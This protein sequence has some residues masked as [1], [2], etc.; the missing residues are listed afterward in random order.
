MA[1]IPPPPPLTSEEFKERV[2]AGAKTMKE[3]DPRYYAWL[4]SNQRMRKYQMVC[5]SFGL[6]AMLTTAV[7]VLLFA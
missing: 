3:I 5:L 1:F 6:V 7:Y 4:Q 2:K